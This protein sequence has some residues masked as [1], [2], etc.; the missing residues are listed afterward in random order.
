MCNVKDCQLLR[1]SGQTKQLEMLV[2]VLSNIKNE[3]VLFVTL[4]FKLSF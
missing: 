4:D 1:L 2:T 3:Q